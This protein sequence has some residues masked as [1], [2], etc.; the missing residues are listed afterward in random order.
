MECTF[1]SESY[2]VDAGG[3]TLSMLFGRPF[4]LTAYQHIRD[5]AHGLPAGQGQRVITIRGLCR[6]ITEG[7]QSQRT[8]NRLSVL[9][10]V[11]HFRSVIKSGSP[12]FG[13]SL[14]PDAGAQMVNRT[15]ADIIEQDIDVRLDSVASNEVDLLEAMATAL[16]YAA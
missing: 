15:T 12:Q 2:A 5:S 1:N 4:T 10:D 3:A 16:G 9:M 13:A 11:F 14:D 7:E 6:S 8:I